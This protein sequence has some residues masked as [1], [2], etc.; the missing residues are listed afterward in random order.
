MAEK[1]GSIALNPYD[2]LRLSLRT[3]QGAPY[4]ELRVY[5]RPTG[6][7]AKPLPERE[8]IL[9]PAEL[10]PLLCR[11]LGQ[12]EEALLKRG[13]IHVPAAE[14]VE[15]TLMAEGRALSR[16]LDGRAE[17]SDARKS[18]RRPL[19]L[20]VTCRLLEADTRA[21]GQP[22]PGELADVSLGGAL[23][24]LPQRLPRF[25]QVELTLSF[26]GQLF[27]GRAEIVGT[28][29]KPDPRTGDHR[30]HLRWLVLDGASRAV[31]AQLLAPGPREQAGEDGEPE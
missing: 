4:L 12:A 16:R 27:R 19:R 28:E 26:Q 18:P 7:G 9:F 17:R 23:A 21:Q 11:M 22:L 1:L 8:P 3:I 6:P 29:G 5:P 2:D 14:A 25:K 15:A 20:P 31:L 13:L 30:H 24:W 10:L